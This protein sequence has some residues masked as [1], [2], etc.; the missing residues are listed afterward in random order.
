MKVKRSFTRMN[1]QFA[2]VLMAGA[3]AFLL[4]SVPARAGLLEISIESPIN[5]NAGTSSDGFDVLLTNLSGPAVSL[6]GFTFEISVPSTDIQLSEA[7]TGTLLDPYIFNGNSLFGPNITVPPNTGQDLRAS[8]LYS[9]IGSGITLGAGA[10]VGLGHI[11]FD[12]SATAHSETVP[13]TFAASPATSLSDDLANNVP[14]N[15]LTNG[16]IDITGTVPEPSYR[17]LLLTAGAFLF[18][19]RT[20]RV[21]RPNR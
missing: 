19:G 7:N 20:L 6:A 8:D 10:T 18:F 16:Q 13:V 1:S 14:I 17:L 12:V 11:L 4:Y 2:T 15:T 5:V 3:A 9:A 21:S